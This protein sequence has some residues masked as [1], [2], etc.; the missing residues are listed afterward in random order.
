VASIPGASQSQVTIEK[1]LPL[2]NLK[3]GQYLLKMKLT[4]NIK[5]QTLTPSV[6]FTVN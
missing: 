3:P 1:L 2:Q 5:K 4:D 6:S